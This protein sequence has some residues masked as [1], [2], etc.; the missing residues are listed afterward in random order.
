VSAFSEHV[1][2]YWWMVNVRRRERHPRHGV[3]PVLYLR[4][5]K[6]A[7]LERLAG[8]REPFETKLLAAM[9]DG[10]A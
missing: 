8:A 5:D 7:Y 4:A 1:A 3:R 2:A 10:S 9:Q 6:I